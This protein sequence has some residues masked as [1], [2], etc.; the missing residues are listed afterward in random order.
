MIDS[1]VCCDCGAAFEDPHM[2][3]DDYGLGG[4]LYE[5]GICC[6]VC[7]SFEISEACQCEKCGKPYPEANS[8][9]HL[10]PDCEGGALSRFKALFEDFL[11]S[12]SAEFDDN[13]RGAINYHWEGEPVC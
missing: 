1:Y 9:F 13:E 8:K 4:G 10:C 11:D 6:P 3:R 2:Y 12:I 7:G 5:T